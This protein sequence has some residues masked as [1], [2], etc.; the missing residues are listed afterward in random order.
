MVLHADPVVPSVTVSLTSTARRLVRIQ[1]VLE[2]LLAQDVRPARVVLWLSEQPYLLDAG[3]RAS[4]VP[5]GL[6]ALQRQGL[7]IRWTDNLGPY[8]KLLPAL[9]EIGGTIVT[10]DDDVLYPSD[11]LSGLL[12]MAQASPGA[13]CCYKAR[14]I[15]RGSDGEPLSY[16]RWPRYRSPVPS[17]DC[18]PIGMGGVLYPPDALHE[19]VLDHA[20]ASRLA[21]TSDD[22]WF[23]AMALLRGTPSR[24]SA[25]P[26]DFPSLKRNAAVGLFLGYNLFGNDRAIRAVDARFRVYSTPRPAAAGPTALFGPPN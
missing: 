16:W 17:A 21:P 14:R 3:V 12:A 15:M 24:A 25:G 6:W 7:E 10:A 22:I 1:P 5:R 4:E 8:R 20:L 23:N 2:R 26:A 19:S 9:H 13:I 18:F 11:W